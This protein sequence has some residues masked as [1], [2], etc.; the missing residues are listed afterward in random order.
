[1]YMLNH[2]FLHLNNKQVSQIHARWKE[3]NNWL[4]EFPP[5]KPN[6]HFPDDQV[7]EILY[8]SIP[9]HWQSYLHCKD[10][11]D[12]LKHL[13]MTFWSHGMLSTHRSPLIQQQNQPKNDKDHNKKLMEKSNDKKCKAQTKKDDSNTPAPK[14]HA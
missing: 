3:I 13:P 9:K 12:I 6:Q 10:K 7:K 1:M 11:F 4:D 2:M 8:S 5:F 14:S